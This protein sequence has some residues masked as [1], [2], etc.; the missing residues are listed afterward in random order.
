MLA[1]GV[2]DYDLTNPDTIGEVIVFKLEQQ[3]KESLTSIKPFYGSGVYIVY[4]HG[5]YSSYDAITKTN[6]PVYVG[7]AGP[8]TPNAASAKLQGTKLHDRMMEH[9][10][11]SISQSRNLQPADFECRYLVVQST[12]DPIV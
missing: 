9:L 11:K 6:C 5:S 12:V 10:R 1:R 8:E 2:N 3:V 7:S 4:Y